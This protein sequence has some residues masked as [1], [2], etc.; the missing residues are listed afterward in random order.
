MAISKEFVVSLKGKEYPLFAGVLDAATRAGLKSLTTRIVQIPTLENGGLAVVMARAEFEDGRV[1]EDVGDASPAN[2]SSQIAAAA[3]RIASTR[4]K[5][6]CLRDALNVGQ[7]L[8]EELPPEERF[9]ETS[10]GP[11]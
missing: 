9:A 6:R 11:A 7:T 8:Y 3:L 2:C 5:G 10:A 4:A 1:F